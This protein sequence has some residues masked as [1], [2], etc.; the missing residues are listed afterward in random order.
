MRST[1]DPT[2]PSAQPAKAEAR[3]PPARGRGLVLR[4]LGLLG[5]LLAATAIFV[6]VDA[7]RDL[8]GALAE[9]RD[10]AAALRRVLFRS[11]DDLHKCKARPAGEPPPAPASPI[12]TAS[13]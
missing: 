1:R 13:P 10:E 12:P 6:L 7:Y 9:A 11:E 8:E 5:V 2:P 4:L 3:R